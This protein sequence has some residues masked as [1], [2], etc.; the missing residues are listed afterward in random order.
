[1]TED[2]QRRLALNEALAR[3]VN[4]VVDGLAAGW[5]DPE[6]P[7]EFRCECVDVGCEERVPLTRD[8]YLGVRS[9]RYWFI[10]VPGHEAL[11]V[12]RVVRR[13]REFVV[14]EKLGAG[15]DVADE[16]AGRRSH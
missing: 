13:A 3:E 1:V 9:N 15:R 12:E 11:E 14:V 8:E 10:V 2:R 4:E 7:I 6:E 16:T 5:F